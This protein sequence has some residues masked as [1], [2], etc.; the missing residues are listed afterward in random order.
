MNK[1]KWIVAYPKFGGLPLGF[2]NIF[3]L[4][5]YIIQNGKDDNDKHYMKNRSNIPI[6]Y[7]ENFDVK[8]VK[9]NFIPDIFVGLPGCAGVSTVG[10]NHSQKSG[11]EYQKNQEIFNLLKLGMDLNQ[12]VIV[13]ESSY[14]MYSNLGIPIINEIKKMIKSQ[15]YSFL[16][17]R[18][19][20]LLHGIPQNRKRCFLIFFKNS[21]PVFEYNYDKTDTLAEFLG[22]IP[23]DSKYYNEYYRNIDIQLISNISDYF[24]GKSFPEIVKVLYPEKYDKIEY[25][26]CLKIIRT[27]GI[28]K[29]LESDK[30]KINPYIRNRLK[31]AVDNLDSG[32]GVWDWSV[33]V[34]INSNYQKPVIY[35]NY[36]YKHPTE[37]RILN[38]R[39]LM[40]LMGMPLDYE[41]EDVPDNYKHIS[42]NVPVNVQEFIASQIKK[43]FDG[44]IPYHSYSYMKQD[45]IKKKIDLIETNIKYSS[46]LTELGI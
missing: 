16:L 46:Y 24:N 4:P 39:E 25:I 12:N 33:V 27:I 37:N 21:P 8:E 32:K 5:E 9:I 17:Y 34:P 3:G 15:E 28:K 23:K 29:F 11:I 36:Q 43:Y 42:R 30:V 35:R 6:I 18:T 20:C 40:S 45:N 7:Q 22:K 13:L 44:Q 10:N 1:I 19:N 2:E 26:S 31:N 14:G 41:I 38:I